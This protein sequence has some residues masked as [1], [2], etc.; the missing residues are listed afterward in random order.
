[1]PDPATAAIEDVLFLVCLIVV[2]TFSNELRCACACGADG[3][4]CSCAE[5]SATPKTFFQSRFP[6]I[7]CAYCRHFSLQLQPVIVL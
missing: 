3:W 1:M 4:T 6:R 7:A 5:R 2:G